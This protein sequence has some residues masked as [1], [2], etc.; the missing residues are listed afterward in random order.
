[1]ERLIYCTARIS[2]A[3]N[4]SGSQDQDV[5]LKAL[6]ADNSVDHI[7]YGNYISKVIKRPLATEGPKRRPVLV[8]PHWPVT[9]QS[10]GSPVTDAL[11]MAS[12]ATFEEK[13]S[14]VN[15]AAHLLVDIL[16]EAVDAVVVISND[17][18]L[19]LPVNQAWQRVPVGLVNPG[20]G[21][22]AGALSMNAGTGVGHIPIGGEPWLRPT[23][24]T[25]NCPIPQAATPARQAGEVHR[26]LIGR[27]RS[28]S[29]DVISARS[30]VGRVS[31]C[32][33]QLRLRTR[34]GAARPARRR[35]RRVRPGR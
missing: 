26:G 29:L 9:V 15:V 12:V 28:A 31:L 10:Q 27:S 25:T 11:F 24:W 7:E 22:T 30:L 18:D 21:F 35:S 5:Y 13:G 19:K 1:V 8:T 14:D 33:N 20:S 16:T 2:A 3:H 34:P 6:L 4:A 23:T 17:S 32:P